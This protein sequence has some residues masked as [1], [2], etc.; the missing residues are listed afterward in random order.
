[1]FD[2]G[3]VVAYYAVLVVDV[4]VASQWPVVAESGVLLRDLSLIYNEKGRRLFLS[5]GG[6][7]QLP[8]RDYQLPKRVADT[9]S[10]MELCG[11]PLETKGSASSELR[12][13]T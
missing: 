12:S 11:R 6:D 9:E 3:C 8:K 5:Y 2:L 13:I 10:S 1:M 7:D 4:G